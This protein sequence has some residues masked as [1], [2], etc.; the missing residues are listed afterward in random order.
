VP[1]TRTTRLLVV[2]LALAVPALARGDVPSPAADPVDPAVPSEPAPPAAERSEPAPLPTELSD[3]KERITSARARPGAL[4]SAVPGAPRAVL[5]HRNEMGPEY[6]LESASYA[7]D[8]ATVYAKV[9]VDGDLAERREFE[10]FAGELAP[11]AHELVV[12]LVYRGVGEGLSRYWDGYRFEVEATHR[13][14]AAPGQRA[15]IRVAGYERAGASE[16][17][18][19]PAVR[20]ASDLA[21]AVN[22][23]DVA[24]A[25]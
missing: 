2:V 23:A 20:F 18:D 8:G 1:R 16:L 24:P 13:F 3:L 14:G 5:V 12:R 15:V 9:D 17:P 6:R 22:P 7:L 4:Q 21:P 19:R 25:R 11:G 10:V